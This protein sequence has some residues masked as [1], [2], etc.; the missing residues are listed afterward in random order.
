MQFTVH[1]GQ[2]ID[3]NSLRDA[4]WIRQLKLAVLSYVLLFYL[5]VQHNSELVTSQNNAEKC[6]FLF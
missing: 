3:G 5:L 1:Y 4:I 2:K 6:N